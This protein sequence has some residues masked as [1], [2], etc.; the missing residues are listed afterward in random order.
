MCR[1]EN[2]IN[3]ERRKKEEGKRDKEKWNEGAKWRRRRVTG[4]E[5]K[6]KR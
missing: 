4:G 3:D 2:R 6:K 1:F 5:G